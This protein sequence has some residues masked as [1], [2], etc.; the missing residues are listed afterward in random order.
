[1]DREPHR[2]VTVL[3]V[4]LIVAILVYTVHRA[5]VLRVEYW[6]GY[7]FLMNARAL[8]GDAAA[9]YALERAPWLALAQIPA[10]AITFGGPPASVARLVVPHLMSALLSILTAAI[11]FRVY[12]HPFGTVLAAVGTLLFVSTPLFV[13]YGAHVMSDIPSAGWV[14]ATVALY[15]SARARPRLATYA[16]CG[17]ALGCAALTRYQVVGVGA[18]LAAA[19]LGYGV[20]E[21]RLD[22]RRWAG[23]AACAA[24][25]AVLFLAVHGVIAVSFYDADVLRYVRDLQVK[26][27]S[28]D[29]FAL[30]HHES[31]RDYALMAPAT[32]SVPIL[33]LAAI[34]LV[35][36]LLRPGRFEIPF[37]AWL[38][39]VGASV[40][41]L[42]AHN[43]A[44]YVFPAL[45]P[46]VY[47]SVRGLEWLPMLAGGDRRLRRAGTLAGV[48]LVAWALAC[49][50]RQ[51]LLDRDPVFRADVQRRA[52]ELLLRSRAPGG[53]LLWVGSGHTFHTRAPDRVPGDEFFD[54]FHYGIAAVQY[55]IG[56]RPQVVGPPADDPDAVAGFRDGDA[57][58]RA[59]D[60][61]FETNEVPAGGV[62]PPEI[63][64][65]HLARFNRSP[66]GDFVPAVDKGFTLRTD[67]T[68][69]VHV[70][71][72]QSAGVWEVVAFD[73]PGR[74]PRS[75]GYL[76]IG[77]AESAPLDPAPRAIA[78]MLL[79]VE[80]SV[81]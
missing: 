14:T 55:F 79:K 3:L 24:A 1:M 47:F 20:Q 37:I 40:V 69:K 15:L 72:E 52:A 16:W 28:A 51:A 77:V 11:I 66:G 80:R 41:L 45:P 19:E 60:N 22:L 57:V 49:G 32:I 81:P 12:R 70:R 6:D 27:T 61:I 10:V 31:W 71:A 44:R 73:Q 78:V 75:L 8:A 74:S 17:L 2:G 9:K 18:A 38:L 46:L 56:E 7:E 59:A 50:L 42:T 63:W 58:L 67:E 62:P 30:S 25:A 53:R 23:L 13:R 4:A 35:R 64:R 54:T 76:D 33:L 21:R 34:G 68:G 5:A 39:L 43:E 26:L 36:A 48:A 29:A 65:I